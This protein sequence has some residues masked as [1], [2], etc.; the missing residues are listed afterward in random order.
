M[1]LTETTRTAAPARLD[2]PPPFARVPV[3]AITGVLTAVL[4]VTATRY[5]YFGD[6]LYFRLAGRNLD[7]SFPDQP[8]LLPLLAA[9]TDWLAPGSIFVLRLPAILCTAAGVVICALLAR[10]L[11]GSRR[12]QVIAAAAFVASPF[13][14]LFG[15][16]LLTST[17][18]VTLT[19]LVTLLLVRWLRT[20][21]DRLLLGVGLVAA[22]AL[23][24]KV[25]IVIYA[26]VL[27]GALL[28][29]GPRALLTRRPLWIGVGIAGVTAIPMLVWQASNGWPQLHMGG[30]LESAAEDKVFGGGPVGFFL[31]AALFCGVAGVLLLGFGLVRVFRNADLRFFGV[32]FAVLAVLFAA[33]NWSGYY[34]AALF[35][36]LWAA[37]AVGLDHVRARWVP[38]VVWP[39]LVVSIGTQVVN[40]PLQPL[41]AVAQDSAR[42]DV[43][44][45]AGWPELVA[46]VADT[47]REVP[48]PAST[49]IM[50]ETYELAAAIDRYGA[51]HDLSQAYSAY[52]GMWYFATPPESAD[53]VL[54][55]GDPPET[56]RSA[57]AS[58][59]EVD[60]TD[61]G[62]G[63]EN[64]FQD[65]PVWLLSGRDTAWAQLWPALRVP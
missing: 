1:S 60:R 29:C 55:I 2:E 36:V 6:E 44:A 25:M 11:G 14:V 53:S 62:L 5:G 4:L 13:M 38:W 31:D 42:F 20:R 12:A 28:L 47:Y 39:A 49:V 37:G 40:L 30:V 26:A 51:E 10:E 52:L 54:Y 27:V 32:A 50:S 3:F 23:Q 43:P 22:V 63:V 15:R 65:L 16:Y 46:D 7:W 64:S 57:F 41:S 9:T 56:L 21:D 48:D 34:V 58:A 24:A 45:T 18:D 61:N 17:I 8:P 59:E 33:M 19:A 35:P